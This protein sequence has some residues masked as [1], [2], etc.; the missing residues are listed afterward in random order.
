MINWDR[1]LTYYRLGNYKC[2]SNIRHCSC[3]T[4]EQME[5]LTRGN[6]HAY[7]VYLNV[8]NF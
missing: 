1:E 4:S 3:R 8:D 2:Y 6:S 7:N 5:N